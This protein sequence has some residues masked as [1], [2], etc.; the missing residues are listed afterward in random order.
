VSRSRTLLALLIVLGLLAALGPALALANGGSA[1]DNQYVDPLAGVHT[2]GGG[3]SGSSSGS[4]AGSSSGSSGTTS[5]T[6]ASGS[7][8]AA[9]SSA[10]TPTATSAATSTDPSGKA[11]TLPFSG[12]ADWQA[13]GLGAVLLAG[14]L[15]LRRRALS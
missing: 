7:A 9:T 8:V 1:G 2:H 12:F 5:G 3:S 6:P 13:A 14:G 11:K 10:T 4:S 15:V